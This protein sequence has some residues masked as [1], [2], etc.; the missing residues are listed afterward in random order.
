LLRTTFAACSV[1]LAARYAA[2]SGIFFGVSLLLTS[3]FW[4]PKNGCCSAIDAA[5]FLLHPLGL[6]RSDH[7]RRLALLYLSPQV[8]I[9]QLL[10]V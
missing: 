7:E 4:P 10:R 8:C 9:L 3:A 6:I 5:F 1:L 2:H